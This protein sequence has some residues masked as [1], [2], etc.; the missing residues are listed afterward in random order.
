MATLFDNYKRVALVVAFI[1]GSFILS[2]H[3]F[4]GLSYFLGA[5]LLGF[6]VNKNWLQFSLIFA[7]YM[8]VIFFGSVTEISVLYPAIFLIIAYFFLKV[9]KEID[10]GTLFFWVTVT[11]AVLFA[12]FMFYLEAKTAFMTHI[13]N[14]AKEEIKDMSMLLKDMMTDKEKKEFITFAVGLLEK[15]HIFFALLQL[16]VF[17]MLNFL[18]MPHIF[19]NLPDSLSQEFSKIKI[20]YYG[21]WGIN[22]GL[23]LYLFQTGKLAVYGINMVLFF[24][25]IYFF[26]GLSFSSAFF[27]RFGV[28]FYVAM[29]F[30][31]LFLVNQAMWLVMSIIGIID[32]QF[33]IR[34]FLK[35]V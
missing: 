28:P 22:M 19:G 9:F 11:M 14:A 5:V 25:S 13:L 12:S 31:L 18:I 20:P 1:F 27:K 15:Y 17:T 33:N 32:S 24:L 3:L 26:Q 21:V 7:A 8:V 34:K 23:I 10:K 2:S 4:A 30:F 16:V 6:L 29:V 35:E